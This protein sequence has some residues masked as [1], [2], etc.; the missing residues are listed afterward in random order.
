MWFQTRLPLCDRELDL[1]FFDQ[2]VGLVGRRLSVRKDCTN[3][4]L[5][6]SLESLNTSRNEI[7][8]GVKRGVDL[9][10]GLQ[11]EGHFCTN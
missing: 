3:E 11:Q 2:T 1:E 10:E 8:V 7:K 5:S 9:F 6:K 4:L